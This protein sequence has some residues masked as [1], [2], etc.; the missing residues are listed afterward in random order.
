MIKLLF[1]SANYFD[2]QKLIPNSWALITESSTEIGLGDGWKQINADKI[3]D[4]QGKT[5]TGGLVD[6]HCHG[7]MGHAAQDGLEGM[8]ATLDFNFKNGVAKSLLSMVSAPARELIELCEQAQDLS[9]DSRFAGIHLEGPY[10][11]H[12]KRGAHNPEIVGKP[13]TDDLK[14]LAKL[15]TARSITIAPELF[16]TSQIDILAD[17]G[18]QLCFGHSE[19]NYEQALDFFKRYPTAIMTHAFN[20]M[21]GIHHRA[22]GPIPAAIETGVMIELIADGIHVE[23][24]AARLLPEDKLILITDAMAA[25]GM[26]DGE[27]KLGSMVANVKNGVART[28]SGSLAG[29]TLLLKDAVANY[30]GWIGSKEKALIAA[31]TNP[32]NTYGITAPKLSLATHFL[33][34]L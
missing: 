8:R 13:T 5:L 25:T 21:N 22:P 33:L 26:P 18:L 15:E 34:D 1:H 32:A 30:A 27:Y 29:S 28:D 16:E 2:G 10:I 3:I 4:A 31:S 12:G 23:E 17:A 19:A 7:A 11:S 24:A 20:G 6:T 14:A 9:G